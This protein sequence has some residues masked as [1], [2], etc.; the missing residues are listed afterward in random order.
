VK[1][2]Y[3]KNS[4]LSQVEL[5]SLIKKAEHLIKA[6]NFK[7]A[8][9]ELEKFK[10]K[11]RNVEFFLLLAEAYEGLGDKEKAEAYFDEAKFLD[12]EIRS[13]EKIRKG[14][15]LIEKRNFKDAEKELLESIELNPFE[16][17]AYWELYKLYREI[18]NY[19][20]M[21]K[22]LETL[23][24]LD[25][26]SESFYLELSH[27][28]AIKKHFKKA[29]EVLLS[30]IERI[31]SADLHFELGK[32]YADMGKMEEAKDEISKAC[33]MD[34]TNIEYR[35]ALAEVM[36]KD[37]SYEEALEVVLST[38]ELYPDAVYVILSAAALF[39]I[40]GKE[41]MAEYYYRLAISKCYDE[42]F[43]LE[44]VKKTF[45]EFLIEKGRYDEAEELLKSMIENSDNI[46][47]LLDAFSD[48]A[49]ILVEQ[50][51]LEELIE[52]GESIL[53][54]PDLP[55]DEYW[56]VA[57]VVADAL[58]EEKRYREAKEY[59]RRILNNS[60]DEKL[61]KRAYSKLKEVE[62][63]ESLENMLENSK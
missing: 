55:E 9:E 34:F 16:K 53:E 45:S 22:A 41:D 40:L 13:K 14:S 11:V 63:I 52:I 39:D 48:L 56:E 35:Q 5:T 29:A 32:I 26:Y 38:L 3:K 27:L 21:V 60:S 33:L 25:P 2:S 49:V 37:E 61:K 8:V 18:G 43:V 62:E 31:G 36:V 50:E 19:E 51:R 47:T 20:G 6:K 4:Y 42:P 57:E 44:D 46:W 54:N 7:K 17:E 23:I 10:H 59:Y 30:G 24:T 1:K 28:Y 12:T 15:K 58:F